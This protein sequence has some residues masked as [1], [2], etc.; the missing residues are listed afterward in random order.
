MTA[1]EPAAVTLQ[2]GERLRADTV[3][4]AAGVRA[5]TTLARAAG[6]E[7]GRGILVDDS[8]RTSAPAVLAAGECAEHRG[9]VY[10][11][12]APLAQQARVAGAT[13]CGDPGAFH[14]TVTATTLKVA[15]V[16]VFSG[17]VLAGGE[18]QDEL[19]WSD[20]RR[21]AY[22]KLVLHEDRLAGAVL[23]GDTTGA[24][25]LSA[26]LRDG[27]RV[28]D[29]LLAPPGGTEVT[30]TAEPEPGTLVCSCNNVTHGEIADAIRTG[31]LATLSEVARVTRA[32]TGCG[33]CSSDVECMLAAADRERVHPPETKA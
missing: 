11:L 4:V 23:V 21:G 29:H 14:G 7:C 13:A 5:E 8:L 1:I 16:H 6:I 22:R 26:L 12:W 33:S 25:E 10:G 3:V 32:S 28:P 15:G 2:S 19:V 18:D 17:G 31:G 30:S 9:T 20:G 24:R 27:E